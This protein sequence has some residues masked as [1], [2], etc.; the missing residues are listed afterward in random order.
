[1]AD[2]E[3]TKPQTSATGANAGNIVALPSKAAPARPSDKVVSFV[4][5]H[6]A[7][8]VAGGLV[9]GAAV[10]ALLPRRLT[11]GPASKALGLAKSAGAASVL[12]GKRA[13]SRLGALGHTAEKEAE[14]ALALIEDKT[15]AVSELAASRLEK[16]AGAALSAASAFGKASGKQAVR[17]GDAA[18]EGAH[19]ASDLAEHLKKSIRR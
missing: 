8:T 3:S 10:A 17:L 9:V 15:G 14:G 19:K 4:K 12:F 13:G 18:A 1:M 16:L 7:V 5:R 6:P 11:R 2:S